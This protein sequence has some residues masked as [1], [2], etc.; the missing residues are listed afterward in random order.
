MSERD[1]FAAALDIAD[2]AGRAA[3]LD[4]ACAGDAELRRRVELLLRAHGQA[5][6]F[7]ERPAVAQAAEA[8]PADATPGATAAFDTARPPEPAAPPTEPADDAEYDALAFLQPPARPDSLGRLGH[9]EVLEVLGKGG[10]GIVFRAFDEML[11][12]VV[13][14]M[15]MAPQLAATSAAR[16]RFLREGRSSAL[17]RH[18]NVVAVYSV[19]EQPIPYLVMEFVAGQTVQQ[20][21]NRVGPLDAAEAAEIGRQIAAGLAA[22]HARGLI[23]RDIKPSNVMLE[24]GT[25]RAKI[26]DFGLA[27]AADDASLT[28]SGTVAGTPMY[29]A[30]EQAKG[31]RIDHRADLFSLGS[32]LYAMSSGR[33][34]F[35][36]STTLAVLKRVA[37]EAPRPI[38][39][40]IPEVPEWLCAVVARLHAKDPAARYQTA[41]EVAEVL[42]GGLEQVAAGVAPTFPRNASPRRRTWG[43]PLAVT[44]TAVTVAAVAVAAYLAWGRGDRPDPP[45]DPGAASAGM[46]T[47]PR[48]QGQAAK[49]RSPLDGRK[50]SDVPP[51]LLARAGGG[52]PEKAAAELVAVLGP[53]GPFTLPR[54]AES[55]APAVSPDGKWLA[56]AC[57]KDVAVFDAAGALRH[58]LTGPSQ[59][60]HRVAFAADGKRVGAGCDDG[61]ACVWDAGSGKLERILQ[62]HPDT[63][64]VVAF[65]PDGKRIA[66]ACSDGSLFL[67]DQDGRNRTPLAK[68][69]QG[70][71]ALAFSADGKTLASAGDEGVVVLWDTAAGTAKRSLRGHTTQVK[72]LRYSPDGTTLASGGDREIILWDPETG[73]PRQTLA[74]SA[75]GLLAF[76]SDGG[77]LLA[78]RWGEEEGGGYLLTRWD[79]AAGKKTADVPLGP[80]R[81]GVAP[82]RFYGASPDGTTVYAC[83]HGRDDR[84]SAFDAVTGK[85]RFPRPGFHAGPV[86]AVA[87]R[88]DGQALATGGDDHAVRLWDLAAW[89]PG[90]VLPPCRILKGHT[91]PVNAL[92]F[93][94]DGKSLVSGDGNGFVL[95]WDAA[96]GKKRRDPL[97]RVSPGGGIAFSPDGRSLAAGQDNGSVLVYDLHTGEQ[98]AAWPA[99]KARVW[100]VA[101]SPDGK[102]IASCG[103]DNL[104][105]VSERLTGRALRWLPRDRNAQWLNL[106]RD[107]R[108][109]FSPDGATLYA[110][111]TGTLLA[112]DAA[113]G[114]ERPVPPGHRESPIGGLA[115]HPG[116][117]LVATGDWHGSVVVR[118]VPTGRAR[119][120]APGGEGEAHRVESLA[121]TPGGRYLV[122]ASASGSV[123]VLRTPVLPPPARGAPSRRPIDLLALAE[124]PRDA[125]RGKWQRRGSGLVVLGDGQLELPYQPP[126]EYDLTVRLTL[127][128]K[129]GVV[130]VHFPYAGDRCGRFGFLFDRAGQLLH[131]STD[132]SGV[133][134][135]DLVDPSPDLPVRREL[136]VEVRRTGVRLVD[137]GAA[138]RLLWEGGAKAPPGFADSRDG[139]LVGLSSGRGEVVFERIAVTELSGRGWY[140]YGPPGR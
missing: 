110:T 63:V 96:M 119:V 123:W 21:L 106:S 56:V 9:Y 11:Q 36:A 101:F 23:H 35:R 137:N 45:A 87:V 129:G 69:T 62:G 80:C 73:E 134:W 99:H 8:A 89:Q 124:L 7:L 84:V 107:G 115:V 111:A 44:L 120:V 41:A 128:R 135:T 71:D 126:K 61:R 102:R 138:W 55:H 27:R 140:P 76:T 48:A 10:F 52:E 58:T 90:A 29:M 14:V 65:S 81:K 88:P 139:G 68:Q 125:I 22:A 50:R 79:L 72:N 83:H 118:D 131:E 67:W 32:V 98:Q 66:T 133:Y 127:S 12:R 18:D 60:I 6:D 85:E 38:R 117:R 75:L 33:P 121:F 100:A 91:G 2:P 74:A 116:G 16:K 40:I 13:A 37:E 113:T 105:R 51:H 103:A 82:L 5:G 53:S 25:G 86:W 19:E 136:R 109:A 4:R 46:R 132:R 49:L 130:G 93:S 59:R 95:L 92:A 15:V 31:D 47:P 97:G 112:W 122:A 24:A 42:A 77:T 43:A 57:G 30:P 78:A 114:R 3:Y 20:R 34:P 70:L 39:E 54:W 108:L 26:T 17:V 104:V 28:Q 1:V 64:H 94:P